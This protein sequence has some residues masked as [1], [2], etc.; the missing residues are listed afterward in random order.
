[1]VT[2]YFPTL[3]VSG[4]PLDLSHLQPFNLEV[5]SKKAGK[6]LRVHVTFTSHCF[7]K[8][9]DPE[10]HTLGEQIID[11]ETSSPRSFCN[12]R[13]S[14]SLRLPELVQSLNHPKTKVWETASRRNWSY[15]IKV[16]D[17]AGPY[18]LFFELRRTPAAMRNHQ[19]LNLTVESAYPHDP[20]RA[21]PRL[22]GSMN[23][24]LL[25]GKVYCGERTSTSR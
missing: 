9:Y 10:T 1:M 8:S 6:I 24:L 14:L 18:H 21:Q 7:T 13:Y 11:R 5:E 19:D 20:T 2:P 16:E 23:F 4:E 17:P 12:V 3:I 15:S 22:L 25:C